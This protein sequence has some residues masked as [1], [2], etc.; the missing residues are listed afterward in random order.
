MT[1][2]HPR[3]SA[4]QEASSQPSAI[5]TSFS[6]C[7]SQFR[8]FYVALTSKDCQGT[9]GASLSRLADEYGRFGV[10]GGNSRADHTG[11]GSLD[12][13]LRKDPSLYSIILDLLD[14][15]HDDLERGM[16]SQ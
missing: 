8:E 11:R 13:S 7:S 6:K 10:W 3:G 14:N 16:S 15:L 12:D 1:P 4:I 9:Q 5:A 2:V